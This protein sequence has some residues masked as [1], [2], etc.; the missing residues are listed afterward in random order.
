[1]LIVHRQTLQVASWPNRDR[2]TPG[3]IVSASSAGVDMKE[4][5]LLNLVKRLSPRWFPMRIQHAEQGRVLLQPRWTLS[6]MRGSMTRSEIRRARELTKL[7]GP[8]GA[9]S[10]NLGAALA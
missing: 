5:E 1:M 3:V 9:F 2:R 7:E 6:Y 10:S 8:C 4:S